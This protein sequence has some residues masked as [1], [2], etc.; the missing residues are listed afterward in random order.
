MSGIT[1]P[2]SSDTTGMHP[3]LTAED[4]AYVRSTF[5]TQSDLDRQRAA[6]GLA[7]QASYLLPDGTPMVATEPDADL[8]QTTDPLDLR[9]RFHTRWVAAGGRHQDADAE[10]EAW[11][12]GGYG[13]CLRSPCPETILAKTALAQTIAAL[14]TRP[15]PQRAWWRE[16]LRHAVAAY[17]ELVLPFASVDPARF[18]GTT[19]RAQLI[20]T[21]RAQWPE[22]SPTHRRD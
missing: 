13:V 16:T 21:V 5:C 12:R 4:V 19:S 11:L 2:S 18:G 22:L 15:M 8:A 14:T 17:D 7:P 20:D 6:A 3:E 1:D 9:Q 10:L